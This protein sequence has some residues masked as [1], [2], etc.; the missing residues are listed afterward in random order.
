MITYSRLG[1]ANNSSSSHSIIFVGDKKIANDY[2]A[3]DGFGWDFFTASDRESK[4][5]YMFQL[6][7]YT[8]ERIF[9]HESSSLLEWQ[10][11]E[12]MQRLCVIKFIETNKSKLTAFQ[13]LDTFLEEYK[14]DEFG[15]YID[16]ESVI[17]LPRTRAGNKIDVMFFN[18]LCTELF[19]D[20]YVILG[21][22]DNADEEHWAKDLDQG[23]SDIVR[24]L[25]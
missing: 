5:R 2:C 11:R 10:L 13:H 14:K 17:P 22:N 18:D 20:G 23:V 4:E 9:P 25:T 3:G 6:L 21:G 16:H 1:F 12:E 19:K 8:A 24:L 15:D 7:I